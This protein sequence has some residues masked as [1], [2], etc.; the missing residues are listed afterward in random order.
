VIRSVALLK[1]KSGHDPARMEQILAELRALR[2]PGLIRMMIGP[3]LGLRQGN[4]DYAI[5][6]ELEDREAYRLYDAD[7]EHNR[8]RGELALLIEQIARCQIEV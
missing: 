1:A 6:T 7:A 5:V 8:L 4:W 2:T 3:D